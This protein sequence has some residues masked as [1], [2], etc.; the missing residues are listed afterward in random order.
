MM[1]KCPNCGSTAQARKWIDSLE[2]PNTHSI[3][4][5][6]CGE[7]FVAIDPNKGEEADIRGLMREP[8][9]NGN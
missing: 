8:W 7:C 3:Y 6:G 1:P 4:F 9:E 2:R 5:C